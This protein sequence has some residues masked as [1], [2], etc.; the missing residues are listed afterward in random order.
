M[1]RLIR[2]AMPSLRLRLFVLILTPLLGVATVLGVWRF[3]EAQ[4]TAE[5]LFDR[6]LLAASLAIS[7]DVIRSEGDALSPRTRSL[8]SDA[9]G[10][11]IF[12]HVTGPGGIYVTGYAYPPTDHTGLETSSEPV[13]SIATYRSEPVRVLRMSEP[14][15]I[16]TQLG[17]TVVTVWQRVSDRN[18]FA[19]TLAWRAFSLIGG[20][21]VTLALVVWFGVQ[22][23]LRPLDDLEDAIRRR[24][25]DDLSRIR[26]AVPLEVRG[27]VDRLNRLLRQVEQ[28]IETHQNFISDAAHQLR[29]PAS[30]LLSLAETLPSVSS[31]EE[32]AQREQELISAARKSARLAEQL[33]SMERLR[34]GGTSAFRTF[35]LWQAV[36][37]VCLNLAPEILARDIR[38][39]FDREARPASLH[40]DRTLMVEAL[41]NLIDNALCHGGTGLSEIIV[42][43]GIEK[44]RAVIDVLDDGKGLQGGEGD[45]VF[46]RFHQLE[47]GEGSGLGLS[48]TQTIVEKHG[49]DIQ[50]IDAL[51][52][53]CFRITLPLG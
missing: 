51:R 13:Y 22:L 1:K 45:A 48:I 37:E 7:R 35:D 43:T 10:G 28:S 5:E 32:R 4:A 33:L 53:A 39:A 3:G 24:S 11:E 41:T 2:Q 25:A 29:N 18:R 36:E 23:G 17:Q 6:G 38:F 42:R 50:T 26:R 49:G 12:Y 47:G 30:A 14:T 40:G 8:I 9:G 44:G 15:L 20:L 19:A 31:A 16:G 34:H 52:G 21:M 27:I 46:H